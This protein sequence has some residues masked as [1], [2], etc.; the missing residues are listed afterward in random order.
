M[1]IIR[2]VL[3]LVMSLFFCLT[4]SAQENKEPKWKR[5]LTYQQK[6]IMKEC[7]LHSGKGYF[8][9]NARDPKTTHMK[10]LVE[11]AHFTVGVRQGKYGNAGSL[12]GDLN[13]V[14][15]KFPNHPQALMVMAKLQASDDFN[16][17]R[18]QER[19]DYLW[20]S[21]DCLIKRAMHFKPNDPNVYLVDAVIKHRAKRL[22]EA[23]LS[24]LKTISLYPEHLEAHYN[25]GLL[26]LDMSQSEKALKHAKV[27]YAGQYPLIGL[28]KRLVEVGAMPKG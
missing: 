26:Y 27:A 25:L 14:L 5:K 3:C 11:G 4:V 19:K 24:Y 9:Y 8:D 1:K 2:N 15:N 22:K 7:K 23:E 28:K 10:S 17:R 20:P 6:E 13:Y 18:R 12:E 21:I 16:P